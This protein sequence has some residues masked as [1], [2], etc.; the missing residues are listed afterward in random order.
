MIQS[1]IKRYPEMVTAFVGIDT[2]PFGNYDNPQ[3][4]NREIDKFI[5]SLP[6]SKFPFVENENGCL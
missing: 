1:F 4:V 6:E 5:W 3:D 2:T